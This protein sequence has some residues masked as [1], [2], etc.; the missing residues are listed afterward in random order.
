MDMRKRAAAFFCAL[1]LTAA[2]LPAAAAEDGS[3]SALP[4]LR[5]AAEDY[6]AASPTPAVGTVQG[7]T[8]LL[9][10]E[11]TDWIEWTVDVP[12]AGSYEILPE[13]CPLT[14]TG[15][16][17]R[18]TVT[19]N[20]EVQHEDHENATLARWWRFT[21]ERTVNALGDE[22]SPA[23]SE[24]LS[25][26]TGSLY[27]AEG[28][29]T[30]PLCFSLRQGKNTIRLT[31]VAEDIALTGLT[32]RAP[33]QTP[34]YAELKADY[35]ARGYRDAAQTVC[36]EA[37]D[38]VEEKSSAGVSVASDSDPAMTP[39]NGDTRRLNMVGGGGVSTETVWRFSVPADGL[40]TLALRDSVAAQD[41][42]ST[43][44][45]LRI[46]GRVPCDELW[47]LALPYQSRWRTETVSAADGEPIRLYLTAGEHTLSAR[48]VCG[49]LSTQYRVI[50]R[51]YL[52]LTRLIRDVTKV[53]GTTPD[54]NYD[55]QITTAIPDIVPRL[56]DLRDHLLAAEEAVRALA[57]GKSRLANQIRSV[58][59][60]LGELIDRPDTIPRRLTDLQTLTST[61]ASVTGSLR[62]GTFSLDRFWLCAPEQT[63]PDYRST[64]WQR[65]G[66][67]FRSFFQ[68][69]VRDYNAV[70]AD[71]GSGESIEVWIARGKEWAE[72]IS[73]L[74]D[75]Y[76][77]PETNIRVRINVLPTGQL[78]AGGINPIMLAIAAGTAPDAAL[79]VQ[80][81]SPFEYAIRGAAADLSGMEGF[82]EVYD[83][84]LPALFTSVRWKNGIYA[85]PETANAR[86]M[87]Y[88][89]DILAELGI[90]P[91]D[92]WDEV[93]GT[94]LPLLYKN[95]MEMC[96]PTMYDVFLYQH[97]GEYYTAD[98]LKSGL[99]TREAYLAFAEL[100]A[101]YTDYGVPVSMN[102][103]NRFRTGEAPIGID[104]LSSYMTFKTAAPEIAGRWSIAPIPGRVRED[105][106]IDRSYAGMLSESCFI[107]GGSD[108]QQAAWRYL[109]WW[110][111]DE[112][113]TRFSREVE[114]RMGTQARWLSANN[115]AFDRLSFTKQEKAAIAVSR[116]WGRDVPQVV[117]GYFSG[118][119]ITNAYTRCVVDGDSPRASLEQCVEDI[120]VELIRRQKDFSIGEGEGS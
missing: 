33:E 30:R 35:A 60:Q 21:G 5:C 83:R 24:V 63:Q 43:Y 62:S 89:T 49:P 38:H 70:S 11:G 119:H 22:V 57:D 56:T 23:Q 112:T 108:R 94:V 17:I 65:A 41:G 6:T 85:L 91:P 113:Q 103:F 28:L 97:G 31:Y 92:T 2:C 75:T 4:E 27:D 1:M 59:V 13:Y 87:Y 19:V 88:R 120:D 16:D 45:T 37:E 117:G 67:F 96:I 20:G 58:A 64:F 34:T 50:Y 111:S 101:L 55:Y 72:L 86:L 68:S 110:T 115:A 8:A 25:W 74:T 54:V 48:T 71:D 36:F 102:F 76:F 116:Q 105:G 40:Y 100:I 9:F 114:Q 18:R 52:L 12:Q 42:I 15:M 109:S 32:I 47:E 99:G 78:N 81:N 66:A 29:Q 82:D 7:R 90:D 95:G 84:F 77:S 53:T 44:H 61:Y 73:R 106:Q 104:S 93:Y 118:R 3:A 98:G 107:L 80:G 79:G 69:F 10:D 46:D 26:R 51:D 14:D 39:A